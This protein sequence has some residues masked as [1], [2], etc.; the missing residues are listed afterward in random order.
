M[1]TLANRLPPRALRHQR[2]SALAEYTIVVTLLVVILLADP[3]AIPLLIENIK[4][5]YT[6]FVYALSAGWI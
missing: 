6:A 1:K 3:T 4:K 2:G 5:A